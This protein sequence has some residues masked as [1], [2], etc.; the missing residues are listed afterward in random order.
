VQYFDVF[1]YYS[2]SCSILLTYGIG[3]E[4][5]FFDSRPDSRFIAR[6]PGILAEMILSVVAVYLL[7]TRVLFHPDFRVLVPMS[8][9]FVCAFVQTLVSLVNPSVMRDISTG[10]RIFYFGTVFLAV[11]EGGSLPE[12]L[13][14]AVASVIAFYCASILLFSVRQR[15]ASATVPADWKGAPLILA[16][17]GLLAIVMHSADIS[18]W[19]QEVYR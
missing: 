15:I 13:I 7:D 19:I 11:S 1:F 4:K 16:S 2:F 9:V 14:I 12:A 5:A 18:W 6:A 17:M 8:T 3:L 10:E